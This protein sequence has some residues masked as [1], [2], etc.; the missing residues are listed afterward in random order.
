[1]LVRHKYT[2]LNLKTFWK[3]YCKHAHIL[4]LCYEG[5]LNSS[6]HHLL[7]SLQASS[8]N[9]VIFLHNCDTIILVGRLVTKPGMLGIPEV[10]AK[11]FQVEGP[12]GLHGKTHL[13]I[14]DTMNNKNIISEYLLTFFKYLDFH[15]CPRSAFMTPFFLNRDLINVFS[16]YLVSFYR[17]QSHLVFVCVCMY[18]CCHCH[19]VL[20]S[21]QWFCSVWWL[22]VSAL[23]TYLGAL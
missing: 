21:S 3:K 22:T 17:N 2:K 5:K 13:K 6:S 19:T 23:L 11:G 4:L 9:R 10:R 8:K 20:S 16:L 1:M 14:S 15:N 7:M 18:C 12:P